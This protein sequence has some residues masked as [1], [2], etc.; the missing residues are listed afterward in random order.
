MAFDKRDKTH[1]KEV[2]IAARQVVT[3]GTEQ[4]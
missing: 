2:P 3:F 4:S 1:S